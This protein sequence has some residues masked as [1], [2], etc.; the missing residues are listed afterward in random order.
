MVLHRP[1]LRS[2]YCSL[3]ITLLVLLS[4]DEAPPHYLLLPYC[5]PLAQLGP[6]STLEGLAIV[7]ENKAEVLID[8]CASSEL[9]L[10]PRNVVRNR[11]HFRCWGLV[12]IPV[13]YSAAALRL[14]ISGLRNSQA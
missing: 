12:R 2:E 3:L 13:V 6:I 11:P 5:A 10:Q 4:R 14:S 8:N 1:L 7:S 9:P